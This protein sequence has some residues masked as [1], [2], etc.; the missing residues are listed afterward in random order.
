MTALEPRSS[1]ATATRW[2]RA[3]FL[4]PAGVALL[5]GLDAALMLLGLPAPVAADR[6]PEVHGMLLVLGFV[7]TVVALERAVA[8]RHPAGFAAPA[9]LGLGAL[10]LIV[11]APLAAGRMALCLGALAMVAVYVP[12]W[13]RQRDDAVLVQAFG[14]VLAAGG[15]LLWLGNV[16]V[17]VLLPWLVGFVVLTIAG[18]RLELARLAMGPRAGPAFLALSAALAGAV[19]AALL[20]PV[21]G[22]PLLGLALLA[23]VGWL[24]VHDAARRTIRSTGLARY[25]AGCLL[26]GYG[27]LAVAG[28]IWLLGG[29]ALDG[30]RY[31]AVVHAVF[32]GFT[33]SMILAHA[34]VILP[35]VLRR[36]LP[37]HPLMIAPGVLLHGSLA[38]RLWAGDA[39]GI[40]L[41]WQVG[42]VLNVTALLLFVG[43]AAWAS[44][45]AAH[46]AGAS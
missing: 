14:A 15:A 42:G 26:A 18:E 32:L 24:A 33:I 11:P 25:I 13:R 3:G 19:A 40:H 28:A 8:L 4:L 38:L 23:L 36:P 5:A 45:R 27:W 46:R 21:P 10:L 35:A 43:V 16:D 44:V 22:Y 37:Y 7:G 2:R 30:P 6:L 20:W 9:G 17:P 31:D 39:R 12:L 34:P 1:Q 29:A 41:A